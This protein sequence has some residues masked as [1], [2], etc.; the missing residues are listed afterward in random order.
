MNGDCGFRGVA[1]SLRN[2]ICIFAPG[3]CIPEC[4]ANWLCRSRNETL[5]P[6][7]RRCAFLSSRAMAMARDAGPN[8]IQ[9]R[10]CTS[11]DSNGLGSG[12][13]SCWIDFLPSSAPRLRIE[14]IIPQQRVGC[15]KIERVTCPVVLT[16]DSAS[17]RHSLS[18]EA[19]TR[20]TQPE[21]QSSLLVVLCL[22]T[23]GQRR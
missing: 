3:N 17:W 9:I 13:S 22:D 6:G 12:I 18:L 15:T 14:G 23:E 19:R 8:P 2:D 21:R 5:G 1:R 4:H 10:S 7:P 11:S 20:A 16:R